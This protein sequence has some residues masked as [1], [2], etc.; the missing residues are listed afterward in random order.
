MGLSVE[1]VVRF[2]TKNNPR[3]HAAKNSVSYSATN[4]QKEINLNNHP[5]NVSFKGWFFNKEPK[6]PTLTTE[7][8]RLYG[9]FDLPDCVLE[10]NDEVTYE[11]LEPIAECLPKNNPRDIHSLSYDTSRPT[12]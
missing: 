10:E 12:E 7:P 11:L 1:K 4:C 2:C 5:N 9:P 6:K 3:G 8:A